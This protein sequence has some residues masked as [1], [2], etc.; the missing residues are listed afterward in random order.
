MHAQLNKKNPDFVPGQALEGGEDA[1]K[2]TFE[3]LS[4][5]LRAEGRVLWLPCTLCLLCATRLK[6]ACKRQAT[7]GSLADR[8]VVDWYL[9]QNKLIFKI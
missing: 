7:P 8:V 9:C 2:W 5:H 3:Q 1:S 4:E 6:Q